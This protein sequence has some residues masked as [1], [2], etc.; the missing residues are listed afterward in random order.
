MDLY[1]L[2]LL[3]FEFYVYVNFFGILFI[4]IDDIYQINFEDVEEYEDDVN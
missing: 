4:V 1:E 3:N 2:L